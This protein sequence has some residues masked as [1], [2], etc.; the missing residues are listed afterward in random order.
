[1]RPA[2][3]AALLSM[4]VVIAAGCATSPPDRGEVVRALRTS[5][6]PASQARCAVDAIYENL[7]DAQIEQLIE[8][9]SGGTPKDDPTRTDDVLDKLNAAMTSCRD[10]ATPT[11]TEPTGGSVTTTSGASF[12]TE[13]GTDAST[14]TA[15]PVGSTDPPSPTSTTEAGSTTSGN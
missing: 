10:L 14:T 7:T 9:G 15:P 5:G 3:L 2:G 1:M 8:R 13:P 12:D 11:T 4:V 6:I